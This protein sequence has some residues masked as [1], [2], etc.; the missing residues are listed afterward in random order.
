HPENHMT[1]TPF[2]KLTAIR[3]LMKQ[4]RID[5]YIIPSS[6]PHISEYLPD[7]YQSIAWVSGFTG[8][9]GTLVITQ[10]FAGLWT[11]SRYF[12]Q[13]T[14]QLADTGFEL[15]GLRTQG[16]AEYADW[17][18]GQLSE[19]AVVA[20]DGKLA[21]VSLAHTVIEKLTPLSI[22][23]KAN[24]DLLDPLWVDRPIL[25]KERAYLIDEKTAG[26]ST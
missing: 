15:V 14:E 2:E 3:G 8:S 21:S 18:A 6:D 20:F 10:Q 5:A 26:R 24:V 25:P 17:L 12:V 13:A 1:M 23:V 7:R 11:D 9:A 19:G 22:V 16:A 4:H